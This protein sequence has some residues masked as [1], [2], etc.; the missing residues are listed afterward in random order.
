[1]KILIK[2]AGM[3]LQILDKVDFIRRKITRNK[4]EHDRMIKR[5]VDE[6]T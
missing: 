3:T 6:E 4:E 1:M 2:K 5:S